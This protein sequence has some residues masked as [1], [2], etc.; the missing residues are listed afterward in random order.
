MIKV[1]RV[2]V[3][4]PGSDQVRVMF[5]I[6]SGQTRFTVPIILS[7]KEFDDTE[8][9]Q[10]ARNELHGVFSALSAQTQEWTMTE[11]DIKQLSSINLRPP[12]Q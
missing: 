12:P 11:D 4:E 7:M 9:I 10:I 8:I 6:E 2:E 3:V 1:A 5:L